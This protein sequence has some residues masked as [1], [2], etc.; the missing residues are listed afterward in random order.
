MG[1][2]PQHVRFEKRGQIP[3]CIRPSTLRRWG[4]YLPFDFEES[5]GSLY[6]GEMR[7]LHILIEHKIAHRFRDL[8]ILVP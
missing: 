2:D 3:S 1:H 6:D 4:C 7:Q 8:G 5:L